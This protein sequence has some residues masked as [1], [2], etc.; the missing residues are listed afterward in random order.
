MK[1]LALTLA[2]LALAAVVYVVATQPSGV[3][4]RDKAEQNR[5]AIA[6]AQALWK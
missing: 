6:E 2:A 4:L 5:N 3:S 1:T